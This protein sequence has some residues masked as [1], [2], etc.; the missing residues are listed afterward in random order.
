[1]PSI[2]YDPLQAVF[3]SNFVEQAYATFNPSN[4]NPVP[5]LFP[6]GWTFQGNLQVDLHLLGTMYFIGWV[7]KHDDGG[8]AI[9]FL[10]TEDLEWLY[11][12]DALTC[13]HPIGGLVEAGMYDMFNSLTFVPPA[14][15]A[16]EPFATYLGDLDTSLPVIVTGHSLGGALT[17]FTSAAIAA[18]VRAP[19]TAALQVYSIASPRVGNAAF[20]SAFNLL[21]PN[22]F[23]IYNIRDYVPTLPPEDLGYTHVATAQPMPELDSWQYPVYQGWNPVTAAECYHSHAVY[24]YMLKAR[25]G[26]NPDPSEMGACYLPIAKPSPV[27]ITRGTPQNVIA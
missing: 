1:M 25:A 22:N 18:R 7:A 24:N 16:S 10:G 2:P 3:C 11:D 20:A 13:S 23:R 12:G 5:P 6:D 17:T 9:V 27:Q 8:I 19:G 26:L 21:V 4:P 15:A 14:S